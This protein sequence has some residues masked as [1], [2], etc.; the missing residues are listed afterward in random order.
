MGWVYSSHL[1]V[2]RGVFN[3]PPED[4]MHRQLNRS[5]HR[6]IAKCFS[7][8][9]LELLK[10]HSEFTD[11]FAKIATLDDAAATVEIG[12]RLLSQRDKQQK[13]AWPAPPQSSF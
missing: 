4:A 8:Q 7:E 11:A 10:S 13:P 1:H 5:A 3:S 9:E 6:L 2:C 12:S